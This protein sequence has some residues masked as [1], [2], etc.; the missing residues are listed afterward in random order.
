[1]S[2]RRTHSDVVRVQGTEYLPHL[3]YLP[4]VPYSI[5]L[6]CHRVG[7]NAKADPLSPRT[8]RI[9]LKAFV[10]LFPMSFQC[11]SLAYPHYTTDQSQGFHLPEWKVMI[12]CAC[13][14]RVVL[15]RNGEDTPHAARRTTLSIHSNC[16]QW[17]PMTTEEIPRA[18]SSV[19]PQSTSPRPHLQ[20]IPIHFHQQRTR[21]ADP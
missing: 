1:M 15:C 13:S 4:K 16:S 19:S 6:T 14:T 12:V 20:S 7:F 11:P 5:P 2:I 8:Y 18:L 21:H 9:N 17:Q 10:V 3:H